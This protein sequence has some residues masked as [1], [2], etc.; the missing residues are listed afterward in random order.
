MGSSSEP[1]SSRFSMAQRLSE[2][3]TP[4]WQAYACAPASMARQSLPVAT[5]TASMPFMMPLLCV[6]ARYG[7][8][9]ANS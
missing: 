6:A 4:S 9:A 3:Y 5:A 2:P 8:A 1:T 7:S